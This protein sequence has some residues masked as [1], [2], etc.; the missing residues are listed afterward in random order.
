M[1]SEVT[2][3]RSGV[4]R[5]F[6]WVSVH[7][8]SFEKE[9]P[10]RRDRPESVPRPRQ[11]LQPLDRTSGETTPRRHTTTDTGK[12]ETRGREIEQLISTTPYHRDQERVILQDP[13]SVPLQ[14]IR[15]H[16]SQSSK[17]LL[18]LDELQCVVSRLRRTKARQRVPAVRRVRLSPCAGPRQPNCPL[19]PGVLVLSLPQWYMTE[20]GSGSDGDGTRR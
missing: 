6:S 8:R 2:Y 12:V 19:T 3:V 9:G 1:V 18:L 20:K 17:F 15:V 10:R 7:G 14:T 5:V 4:Q 16:S 11:G 13:L